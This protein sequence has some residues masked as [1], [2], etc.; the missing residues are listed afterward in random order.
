MCHALAQAYRAGAQAAGAEVRVADVAR[1]DF[2][3]L[4][5]KQDWMRGDAGPPP[6][7]TQAVADCQWAQHV[8]I[9]YPLWMG[10]MPALLK[11]FIEQA[12]RPGVAFR[13][14]ANMMPEQLFRGKSA[15]V[16]ITMG[17]PA[18]VYRVFCGA[19][20]LKSLEINIL[21]F[22]GVKPIRESLFGGAESRTDAQRADW[23][24]RFEAVGRKDAARL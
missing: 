8:L 4:R 24:R 9:I 18:L 23:L 16:A 1:L 12:F 6:G 2:P 11:A 5:Q 3:I 7:L 15:R 19:H 10:T 22:V 17:M 13:Y 14:T 21:R 20:S